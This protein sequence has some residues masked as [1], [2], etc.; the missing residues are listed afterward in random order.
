MKIKNMEK[1]LNKCTQ[2]CKIC[3]K[4]LG[5]FED[6]RKTRIYKR[7]WFSIIPFKLNGKFYY[8]TMCVDCFFKKYKR[9]PKSPNIINYDYSI[10]IGVDKKILK[11]NRKNNATTL[12]NCIKRH[13]EHVG[14][15]K[16]LF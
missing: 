2:K 9:I 10:M 5:Y 12:K 1:S 16:N 15:P 8:R 11:E 6:K 4:Q 3:N 7:E 14:K 13:G